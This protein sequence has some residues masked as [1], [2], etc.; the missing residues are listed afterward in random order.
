MKQEFRNLSNHI[1]EQM[2]KNAKEIMLKDHDELVKTKNG[3]WLDAI[4]QKENYGI[5][6]YTNRR[7]IIENICISDIKDFMKTLLKN[8]H[9]CETLMQPM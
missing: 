6:V 1:E 3:F 5:D 8:S 2:F 9:F 4:W 7:K